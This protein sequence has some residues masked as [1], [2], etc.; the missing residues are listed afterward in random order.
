MKIGVF[1]SGIGGLSVVRAIQY[2]VPDAEVIFRN[3][4]AN[5]PYGSKSNAEIYE[6]CRPIFDQLIVDGC[7][8]IVV[9]CNTVTT[10]LIQKLR[11]DLL[12]PLI[13]MEP[14]VKPAAD[15]STT[16]VIAVCATPRTLKSKRYA[17]LKEEYAQ[18][19][20]VLEPNCSDWSAMIESNRIDHEKI[21]DIV[22]DVIAKGADIIVL[23]CTHY[24]WIEAEI[25]KLANGR[26]RV[27]QPEVPVIAQLKR[28]LPGLPQLS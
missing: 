2:A 9:A 1:D 6:L 19:V 23:G 20:T 5:V 21:R 28:V 18:G 4:S 17:W 22:E 27:L 11:A 15:L 3:D 24:H 26:A 25:H 16:K 14:M 8:V 10:N 7:E 12:V 13:G